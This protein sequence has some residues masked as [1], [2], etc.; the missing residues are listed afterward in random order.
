MSWKRKQYSA[1]FK[2]KVAVT[3]LGQ[4]DR[5]KNTDLDSTC[6]CNSSVRNRGQAA[7]AS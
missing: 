3:A 6:K 4:G 5:M 1:E 2:A 7:L